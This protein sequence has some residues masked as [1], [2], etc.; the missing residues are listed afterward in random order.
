MLFHAWQGMK[1]EF[2]PY[3]VDGVEIEFSDQIDLEHYQRTINETIL[4][5]YNRRPRSCDPPLSS[6]V[7]QQHLPI[8][9][10]AAWVQQISL[11]H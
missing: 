6:H 9:C 7:A 10:I 2:K 11:E 3:E 5:I 4:N 1:E 8:L